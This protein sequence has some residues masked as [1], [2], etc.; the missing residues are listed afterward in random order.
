[1]HKGLAI[2]HAVVLAC[3]VS[4]GCGGLVE[5]TAPGPRDGGHLIDMGVSPQDATLEADVSASVDAGDGPP[6]GCSIDAS[7]TTRQCVPPADDTF[8]PT[9]PVISV[10]AGS[11]GLA[12]FVASGPWATASSMQM[13]LVSS[14][15]TLVTHDVLSSTGPD[16]QLT[17]LVPASEVG[18]QGT[19]TVIGNAGNI[20]R[21]AHVTVN[22]TDCAPWSQATACVSYVCGYEPDGCG[23]LHNCGNCGTDAPYCYIGTCISSK[24]IPCYAGQGFDPDGGQCI[25]CPMSAACH[26]CLGTCESVD[27]MCICYTQP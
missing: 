7:L 10:A 11:Y 24:P 4:A 6:P 19:L 8:L 18:R 2:R 27:D 14:T 21:T 16:W 15:L 22:V 9:Q 3:G 25:F 13:D 23:G 12:T 26:R 5:P 20:Q 17:F 1:M